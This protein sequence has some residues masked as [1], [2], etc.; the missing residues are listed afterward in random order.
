MWREIFDDVSKEY[1]ENENTSTEVVMWNTLLE[2][3]RIGSLSATNKNNRNTQEIERLYAENERINTEKN[4]L[5]EE[6]NQIKHSYSY[7]FGLACSFIPRKMFKVV[8]KNI[9]K[10]KCF[11]NEHFVL[12][13]K[14]LVMK[15]HV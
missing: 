1:I 15:S 4:K 11:A 14:R 5:N 12:N 3:Y 13:F 8:R 10:L 7:R 9:K 2:H 6:Y